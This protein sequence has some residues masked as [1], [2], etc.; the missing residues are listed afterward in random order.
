MAG[1]KTLAVIRSEEDTSGRLPIEVAVEKQQ[2]VRED[3]S[4]TRPFIK[5][6]LTIGNRTVFCDVRQAKVLAE[7]TQ[8][9]LPDALQALEDLLNANAGYNSVSSSSVPDELLAGND[10]AEDHVVRERKVRTRKR[11]R[12]SRSGYSENE[13]Y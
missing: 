3:E 4:T 12:T 6:R 2:R 7:L 1:Y 9:V 10:C 5:V 13:D 8:V 11:R